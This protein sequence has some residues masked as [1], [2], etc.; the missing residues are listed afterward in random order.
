M[1]ILS[2]LVYSSKV[3]SD[4]E[5]LPEKLSFYGSPFCQMGILNNVLTELSREL[6]CTELPNQD[7]EEWRERNKRI[8]LHC[9]PTVS[10]NIGRLVNKFQY[11]PALHPATKIILFS[12]PC[13]GYFGIESIW[14]CTESPVNLIIWV[15]W[16]VL[17]QNGLLSI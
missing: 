12:V 4:V 14:E 16:V 7:P 13:R 1:A 5:S 3:V 8:V 10:S 2:T 6:T 9:S 11:H 15:K 17:L